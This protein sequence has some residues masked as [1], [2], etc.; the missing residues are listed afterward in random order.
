MRRL[1]SLAVLASVLLA[2][3]RLLSTTI[4]DVTETGITWCADGVTTE[5]Y[6]RLYVNETPKPDIPSAQWTPQTPTPG[7]TGPC[8]HAVP[9]FAPMDGVQLECCR[10]TPTPSPIINVVRT[11][12]P[13]RLRR[14]VGPR[15]F[16]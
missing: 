14:P 4:T 9:T 15:H 16:P 11:G 6:C 3:T 8:Y 12:T 7:Q 10:Y 13:A 1:F 2:P 5:N